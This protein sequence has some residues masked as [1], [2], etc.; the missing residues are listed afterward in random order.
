MNTDPEG[1]A[2]T[3]FLE[4]FAAAARIIVR[5][6]KLLF[7]CTHVEQLLCMLPS[8]NEP[9]YFTFCPPVP[10]TQMNAEMFQFLP[11]CLMVQKHRRIFGSDA[12]C[13]NFLP[14]TKT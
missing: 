9:M 3:T 6:A 14:M 5:S 2:G 11:Q 7:E 13:I 12:A 10:L 4:K 8:E 1:F